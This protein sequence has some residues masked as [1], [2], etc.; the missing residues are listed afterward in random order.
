MKKKMKKKKMSRTRY[1]RPDP[2]IRKTRHLLQPL[3]DTAVLH[4]RHCTF[5]AA[6]HTVMCTAM[7]CTKKYPEEKEG[8]E[9]AIRRADPAVRRARPL[10]KQTADART[11]YSPEKRSP[12][13]TFV[14][15]LNYIVYNTKHCRYNPIQTSG[16]KL[17]I[18]L[19]WQPSCN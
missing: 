12:S 17:K 3:A 1:S 10:V 9:D 16:Y 19:H 13:S 18:S 6:P 5:C 2:A 7:P 4:T 11:P 15:P 14:H 8:V